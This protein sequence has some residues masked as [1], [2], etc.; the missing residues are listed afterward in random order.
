MDWTPWEGFKRSAI[1]SNIILVTQNLGNSV[2]TCEVIKSVATNREI[3]REQ[4]SR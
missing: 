2:D 4:L 3:G 1:E